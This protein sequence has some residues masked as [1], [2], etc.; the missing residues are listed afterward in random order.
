MKKINEMK[1]IPIFQNTPIRTLHRRTASIRK[2]KIFNLNCVK[3]PKCENGHWYIVTLETSSGTY[4]KEFISSDMGRCNPSFGD[5]VEKFVVESGGKKK[6]IDCE[7]KYLDVV[8][9]VF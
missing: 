6:K 3:H 4:I 5:I 2:K 1:E 9:V 7:I 8:S